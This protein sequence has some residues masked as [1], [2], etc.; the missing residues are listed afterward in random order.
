MAWHC[1]AE[2]PMKVRQQRGCFAI[3]RP[4]LHGCPAQ[5]KSA[6]W[7]RLPSVVPTCCRKVAVGSPWRAGKPMRWLKLNSIVRCQPTALLK[8][9]PLVR[10]CSD[11]SSEKP[12]A[13]VR[14]V[15][16]DR[17]RLLIQ[18][19]RSGSSVDR[20]R[21]HSTTL[22]QQMFAAALERVGSSC[23]S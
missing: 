6:R 15:E 1:R 22:K 4:L 5:G 23:V 11:P 21:G 3:R 20:A 12:A 18:P 9:C 8:P 14:A 7:L 13:L 17:H 10:T 2:R 19:Y 16:E